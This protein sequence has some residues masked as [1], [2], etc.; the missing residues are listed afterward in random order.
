MSPDVKAFLDEVRGHPLWHEFLKA[1]ET[2]R[3][4][5][6]RKGRGQTSDEARDNWIYQSGRRDEHD[7]IMRIL[8]GEPPDEQSRED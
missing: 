2:P 1:L 3:V 5:L 4:P 7:K 8:A 6:W